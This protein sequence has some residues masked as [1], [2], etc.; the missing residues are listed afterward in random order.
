MKPLLVVVGFFAL[1]GCAP[2][3]ASLSAGQVG[4]R[5]SEIT[6]SDETVGNDGFSMSSENWVAEC[7]GKRFICTQ[8]SSASPVWTG[9]GQTGLAHDTDVSC[10]E[11]LSSSGSSGSSSSS[12]SAPAPTTPPPPTT[13]PPKGGVGFELGSK[14]EAAQAACEGAGHTWQ[15]GDEKAASCSGM[16]ATLGFAAPVTF[17]LCTGLICGISFSHTPETDWLGTIAELRNG[18][19]VK[20]GPARE[21][22]GELPEDCRTKTAFINCLQNKRVRLRY[23]WS[24]P[25]GERVTLVVGVPQQGGDAAIHL[26]YYKSPRALSIDESAL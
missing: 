6:I 18:L 11:E 9:S 24:W 15:P 13:A 3:R 17:K 12:Y 22:D 10:K 25:S 23:V 20:Y 16:A 7:A 1:G 14:V 21:R 5:P 19:E 8:I 26:V 2:S 4:C